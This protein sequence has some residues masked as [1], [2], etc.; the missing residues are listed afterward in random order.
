MQ[1]EIRSLQVQ[2][3]RFRGQQNDHHVISFQSLQVQILNG[4]L[5]APVVLIVVDNN[6]HSLPQGGREG[7]RGEAPMTLS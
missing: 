5:T 7:I 2:F 1:V 6:R 3:Y 4:R